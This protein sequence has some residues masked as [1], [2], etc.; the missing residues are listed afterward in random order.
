MARKASGNKQRNNQSRQDFDR[1]SS[2][3]FSGSEK[4]F[5]TSERSSGG[6][7]VS[8]M[9]QGLPNVDYKALVSELYHNPTVRY[10]AGGLAAAVLNRMASRISNRYPEI[11]SFLKENITTF[12]GKLSQFKDGMNSPAETH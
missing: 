4:N 2:E 7:G 6:R 5:S 11:G 3:D 12:E 1:D 8:G 10:I 9:A